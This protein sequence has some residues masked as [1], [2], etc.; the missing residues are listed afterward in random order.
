MSALTEAHHCSRHPP[1]F[2][3][4]YTLPRHNNSLSHHEGFSFTRHTSH[5]ALLYIAIS[6][7]NQ[8]RAGDHSAVTASLRQNRILT[9]I[10]NRLLAE[11]GT[12]LLHILHLQQTCVS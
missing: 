3:S 8:H 12:C 1:P 4:P 10:P 2:R 7:L 6:E 5:A 11:E 9:L